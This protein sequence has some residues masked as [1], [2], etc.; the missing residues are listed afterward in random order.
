MPC[1]SSD[2]P[3]R[4]RSAMS[5]LA[6]YGCRAGNSNSSTRRRSSCDE[7]ANAAAAAAA[8][9]KA[10]SSSNGHCC[11][12]QG[13]KGQDDGGSGSSWLKKTLI[14]RTPSLPSSLG[15]RKASFFKVGNCF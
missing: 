2:R 1:S 15:K 14:G 10:P 11:K 4:P 13:N 7:Q 9:A 5:R 12:H 8:S 3:A 6:H